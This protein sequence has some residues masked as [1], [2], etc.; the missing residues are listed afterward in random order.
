MRSNFGAL[1]WS[2]RVDSVG[3]W[4]DA[5][6]NMHTG[7]YDYELDQKIKAEVEAQKAKERA[8]T[9]V[10]EPYQAPKTTQNYLPWVLGG[11]AAI[12]VVVLLTKK[13]K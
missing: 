8:N 5:A 4:V 10:A 7:N 12:A 13:S 6:G 3:W 9:L 11:V 2:A 1:D